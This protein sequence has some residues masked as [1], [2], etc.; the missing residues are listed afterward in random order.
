MTAPSVIGTATP[1]FDTVDAVVGGVQTIGGVTLSWQ[2]VQSEPLSTM[3]VPD[4]ER[5]TVSLSC[6]L[7]IPI[8]PSIVLT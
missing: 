4:G 5:T 6:F 3:A 7:L 1:N 2:S 8:Q